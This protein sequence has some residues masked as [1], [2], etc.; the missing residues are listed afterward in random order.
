MNSKLLQRGASS[1]IVVALIVIIL[2]VVGIVFF[3]GDDSAEEMMEDEAMMEEEAMEE[4]DVQGATLVGAAVINPIEE[5][6]VSGQLAVADVEGQ[7]IVLVE[8]AG[9]AEDSSYPAHIHA[10]TC[11]ELGDVVYPLNNIQGGL[12]ETALEEFM[13]EGD[14][15]VNVHMSEEDDSSIACGNLEVASTEVVEEVIEGEAMEEEAM[16]EGEAM[17]EVSE[18]T[19][20]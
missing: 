9:F 11:E 18:E 3:T 13:L 2:L 5:S 4:G 20:Q 7:I 8:L 1:G 19:T 10:G 15:V 14:H 16:E 12:S 6:E 17:E